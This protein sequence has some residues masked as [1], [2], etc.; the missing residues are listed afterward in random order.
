M[1]ALALIFFVVALWSFAYALGQTSQLFLPAMPAGDEEILPAA[2]SILHRRFIIKTA[3]GGYA[4]AG[5][6]AV[7]A[8]GFWRW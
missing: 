3:L 8:A 2:Y 4:L 1:S 6:Y 5:G 7:A